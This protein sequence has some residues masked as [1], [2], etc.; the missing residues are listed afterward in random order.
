MSARQLTSKD[1]SDLMSLGQ[2]MQDIMA[3]SEQEIED[4]LR[5]VQN[6]DPETVRQLEDAEGSAWGFTLAEHSVA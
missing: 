6:F 5:A 1:V 4:Q 2:T 3:L